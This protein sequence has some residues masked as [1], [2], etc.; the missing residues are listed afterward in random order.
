MHASWSIPGADGQPIL[1][2]THMPADRSGDGGAVV[3]IA[4]GFKG[5][6]DYGMFPRLA[7]EFAEAGHLALRFNFSHSGMTNDVATFARP[8]LFERATWNKDVFDLTEVLRAI[9]RGELEGR[10]RPMFVLGHSRGGVTAILTAAR[11]TYPRT[12]SDQRKAGSTEDS[13]PALSGVITLAAPSSCN[14]LMPDQQAELLQQGWIESPSSRTGQR[15]RIGRAFVQEQLDDPAGHDL[16]AHAA[17]IDCPI[18]VIHGD[19][20]ETVPVHAAHQIARSAS[21]RATVRLVAGGDHVFN[22]PNPL[23]EGDPTSVQLQAAID[24]TLA[25]IHDASSSVPQAPPHT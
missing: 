3:V 1:G 12:V 8:D 24:A 11:L 18:L 9:S 20:D 22:T 23:P 15:L 6:K 17:R 13:A 2:D 7:R 14:P 5:Y 21:R 16:L 19:A 4:H 25:F 10:G